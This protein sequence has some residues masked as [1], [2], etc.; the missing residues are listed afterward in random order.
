M[1]ALFLAMSALQVALG[2][3]VP[4]IATVAWLRAARSRGEPLALSG[5]GWGALVFV[6]SQVVHLPLN[7]GIDAA[8]G[9][10]IRALPG[11]LAPLVSAAVLGLS[12]GLCEELARHAFF[13]RD[14]RRSAGN[15]RGRVVLVGLGHGGIESVLVGTVLVGLTVV[16]LAVLERSG[17]AERVT[18]PAARAAIEAALA[19]AREAPWW[20]PLL[21][22]AERVM[23]L[24]FHVAASALVASSVVERRPALL[25]AAILWHAAFDAGAVLL[26]RWTGAAGAE[27]GLLASVPVS[28]LVLR[29]FWRRL[30]G[31]SRTQTS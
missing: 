3:A 22:A 20:T 27:L 28:A 7:F 4:S 11:A 14:L 19:S 24:P 8:L 18:D 15:L 13:R 5:V 9:P 30:G 6:A 2:T 31:A 16:Q 17:A 25:A 12:A 1:S 29:T 26:M 23:A 21:G 10:P